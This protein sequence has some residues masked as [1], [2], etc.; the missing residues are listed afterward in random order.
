MNTQEP[1]VYQ[2]TSLPTASVISGFQNATLESLHTWAATG[3]PVSP[4]FA[5]RDEKTGEIK[6]APYAGGWYNATKDPAVIAAYHARWPDAIWGDFSPFDV[7]VDV[8]KKKGKDGDASL[9]A[10]VT[11]IKIGLADGGIVTQT[12]SGGRHHRFLNP[13][14]LDIPTKLK[15][16]EGVDIITGDHQGCFLWQFHG[17]PVLQWNAETAIAPMPSW[18]TAMAR[19][20]TDVH[21][22]TVSSER[23]K[24]STPPTN[25]TPEKW[26]KILAATDRNRMAA[27]N[28][29]S[30]TLDALHYDSGGAAWALDL[31]IE[32]SATWPGWPDDEG[33]E[34][35]DYWNRRR[36]PNVTPVTIGTV[37]DRLPD[38]VKA[39]VIRDLH[40]PDLTTVGFGVGVVLPEGAFAT[41]AERDAAYPLQ[42]LMT[43]IEAN[44][45]AAEEEKLIPPVRLDLLELK[46]NPPKIVPDIIPHFIV[47]N[48]VN[49]VAGH[50]GVGKSF[51]ELDQAVCIA[52]GRSWCGR[53]VNQMG[54]AFYEFEDDI[55]QLWRRVEAICK[56]RSIPI[57]DVAENLHIFDGT[58]ADS[59]WFEEVKEYGNSAYFMT[60]A[61]KWVAEHAKT[62]GVQ[63]IFVSGISDVYGADMNDNPAVARFLIKLRNAIPKDG[64]IVI[65]GHVNQDSAKRGAEGMGTMG[66]MAWHNKVRNRVFFYSTE[67]DAKGRTTLDCRK[68]QY[69]DAVALLRM[70]FDKDADMFVPE[71]ADDAPPKLDVKKMRAI[72]KWVEDAEDAGVPITYQRAATDCAS[73]PGFDDVFGR[74]AGAARKSFNKVKDAMIDSGYLVIIDAPRKGNTIVKVLSVKQ[75]NLMVPD[76]E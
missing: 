5:Y 16:V 42:A 14:H 54:V 73:K 48:V 74:K 24:T 37:L 45:A 67:Q 63:G 60:E 1:I 51:I 20:V 21:N 28:E 17:F 70:R 8:D 71:T 36:N 50:G 6:R 19:T 39:S 43:A 59:T 38:N 47:A 33:V 57:E 46:R 23:S 44:T 61:F 25:A 31:S 18:V 75:A 3:R 13:E 26:R 9:A 56:Y 4:W 64:F 69:G 35:T 66:A 58:K 53:P 49:L 52:A 10:M 12:P 15:Y 29:W 62:A 34:I 65:I 27:W 11:P 30:Q 41:A 55:A 22:G 7:T 72:A 76:G 68:N 32:M 2:K 40:A